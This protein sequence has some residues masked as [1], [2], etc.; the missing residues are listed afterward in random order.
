MKSQGAVLA[1]LAA[2]V[3]ALPSMGARGGGVRD[4]PS[5]LTVI[6][7]RHRPTSPRT[8]R[9]CTTGAATTTT[10]RPAC[11]GRTSTP[12][13][14]A[15]TRQ[16]DLTN[17][18]NPV[19]AVLELLPAGTTLTSTTCPSPLIVSLGAF[20]FYPQASFP[21]F[22]QQRQTDRQPAPPRCRSLANS[23]P[24]SS[25]ATARTVPGASPTTSPS[26]PS[27]GPGTTP[28]PAIYPRKRR[29]AL[30][31]A[32]SPDGPGLLLLFPGARREGGPLSP[33]PPPPSLARNV[34]DNV[35]Y[36]TYFDFAT[37]PV[38]PTC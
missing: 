16:F 9:T 23:D 8:A 22:D 18:G 2:S 13:P 35:Y 27:S 12:S 31:G 19:P 7:S 25:S 29:R 24:C 36:K 33:P 14:A 5:R 10:S 38:T 30:G 28:A 34:G 17:M 6:C 15:G 21:V 4:P 32:L 11:S 20:A 37:A 26:P 3:A 1:S